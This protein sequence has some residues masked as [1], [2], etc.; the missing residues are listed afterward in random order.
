MFLLYNEYHNYQL[1]VLF[2]KKITSQCLA[3]WYQDYEQV[4][5]G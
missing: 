3:N 4:M 2:K 1:Q 5:L